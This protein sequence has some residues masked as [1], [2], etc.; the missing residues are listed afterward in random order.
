MAIP[1]F[2]EWN[3]EK[4]TIPGDN[5]RGS[6]LR[7]PRQA[8]KDF[9][10]SD[11]LLSDVVKTGIDIANPIDSF[12]SYKNKIKLG[13]RAF[14]FDTVVPEGNISK[15][16]TYTGTPAGDFLAEKTDFF[17]PTEKVRVRDVIREVPDSVAKI[18]TGILQS[19]VRNLNL[20]AKSGITGDINATLEPKTRFEEI[21]TGV[22]AGDEFNYE[23]EG[24]DIASIVGQG[25]KI[26]PRGAMFLGVLSAASDAFGFG[27]KSTIKTIAKET[28]PDVIKNILKTEFKNLGED[29][30]ESII[31]QLVKET[32]EDGVEKILKNAH[33][34]EE[35]KNI[36]NITYYHGTNSEFDKFL[37]EKISTGEG[38]ELWGPGVYITDTKDTAR[39][40]AKNSVKGDTFAGLDDIEKNIENLKKQI[41]DINRSPNYGE[42]KVFSEGQKAYDISRLQILINQQQDVLNKAVIKQVKVS[43]GTKLFQIK[44]ITPKELANNLERLKSLGFSDEEI[45]RIVTT[46]SGKKDINTNELKN[47][48]QEKGYDGIEFSG[49]LVMGPPKGKNVVIFDPEKTFISGKEKPFSYEKL[50]VIERPP[51]GFKQVADILKKEVLKEPLT[52]QDTDAIDTVIKALREAKPIRAGQEAIY[53][54]ERSKRLGAAMAVGEKVKGEAGFKAQLG[55]LKGE[56]PKVEFESL[57]G[58]LSQDTVDH[59]FEMAKNSNELSGF[60][61]IRAQE[62][63]AKLFGEYG[64]QVPTKSEIGLLERVFPGELIDELLTK[65]PLLSK[66]SDAGLQLVNIPRSIMSGFADLSF[67]LRQGIFAAPRFRKQFWDSWKKQFKIFGS[68]KAYKASRDALTSHADFEL[69]KEAGISFTDVGKTISNR[70]ED[71][72]SQWAEKIPVAGKVIRATGRAYTAFANKYRMD[73]FADMI[74]RADELG[75]DPRNNMDQLKNMADFVNSAT[76]RG[77]LGK[78]EDAAPVLN[79]F[80]FSPRLIA[81]RLDLLTKVVQPGFWLNVDPFTRKETLKTLFTYA[82]TMVGTLTL[83][84]QIPG[85]EVGTDPTS[86]DFGKVKIGNTRLD[87]T[88]GFQQYIRMAAQ[89]ITGKYTSTTSGKTKKLGE[90]YKPLTRYDIILRQIESKE[91]PIPSFITAILRQQDYIGQPVSV[92]D[93]IIKRVTPILAQDIYEMAKTNPELLPLQIPAFFGVGVQTYSQ[94]PVK[95]GS[96]PKVK[97]SSSK[98]I[99]S[100]KDYK[101]K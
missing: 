60:E 24:R 66:W 79:A 78:L 74:K 7:K 40:Y 3:K 25:E 99:P 41:D 87:I 19:I 52:I 76:G 39:F 80:F 29:V 28:A 75:L 23:K 11:S 44:N 22:E 93:E 43:Q 85:V 70:E 83:L 92:K 5:V 2:T 38:S 91:A 72:A 17:K 48:L 56:I 35:S 33:L 14:D 1:N 15:P 30:V 81:S 84:D 94:T 58:K 51:Q 86:A 98:S 100:F 10:R 50:N 18:G 8:I 54:A 77:S 88:G 96:L 62:G 95:K 90:G 67:G 47:I 61:K 21:L 31:P 59:L 34:A 73:I 45:K 27:S 63:L 89:L 12:A 65:R 20:A 69:A 71:F 82:G 13:R 64:G 55:Q 68:E 4:E 57:K 9:F 46:I 101:S 36:P 32:T 6:F 53:S 16:A 26:S 97:S 42:G 37:P 49:G